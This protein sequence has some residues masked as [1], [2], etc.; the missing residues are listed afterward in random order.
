MYRSHLFISFSIRDQKRFILGLIVFTEDSQEARS[1]SWV[2]GKEVKAK[3]LQSVRA[4]YFSFPTDM[5]SR[6]DKLSS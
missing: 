5:V 3:A 6:P 2:A 1:K 4:T